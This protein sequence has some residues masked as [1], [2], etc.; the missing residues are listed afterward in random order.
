MKSIVNE[1]EYGFENTGSVPIFAYKVKRTEDGSSTIEKETGSVN[2]G[3]TQII[4][5]AD[6][7][8]YNDYEEIKIIP[9]LLGKKKKSGQTQ[10]FECP[11]R[12]GVVL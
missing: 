4:P 9:I 2:P 12:N 11:E 8:V 10:E 1:D 5:D 6:G 3:Y 7:K